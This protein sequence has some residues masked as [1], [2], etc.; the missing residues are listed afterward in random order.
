MPLLFLPMYLLMNL[1]SFLTKFLIS[2]ENCIIFIKF[3]YLFSFHFFLECHFSVLIVQC[4]RKWINSAMGSNGWNQTYFWKYFSKNDN[5]F[6]ENTCTFLSNFSPALC[7]PTTWICGLDSSELWNFTVNVISHTNFTLQ[8][9]S[10]MPHLLLF[11][12]EFWLF[13]EINM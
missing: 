11:S 7:M 12:F 4:R 8:L 5:A 9:K 6:E 1:W 2:W 10:K 13:Q 3:T